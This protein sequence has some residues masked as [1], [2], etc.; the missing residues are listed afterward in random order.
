M[1]RILSVGGLA[2]VMSAS[3]ALA[4]SAPEAGAAPAA[5]VNPHLVGVV[6]INKG[7]ADAPKVAPKAASKP[8]RAEAKPKQTNTPARPTKVARKARKKKR[9]PTVLGWQARAWSVD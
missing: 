4:Q 9:K 5:T 1:R 7:A 6:I 2:V 3:V 8:V